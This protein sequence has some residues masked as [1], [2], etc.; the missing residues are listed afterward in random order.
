MIRYAMSRGM[1]IVD[2]NV[3]SLAQLLRER[4]FHTIVPPTGMSDEDIVDLFCAGRIIITTN[5]RDFIDLAPIY[6]FGIIEVTSRAM[7]DPESVAKRISKEF[8]KRSLKRESPF[9]LKITPH[10]ITFRTID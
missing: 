2:E 4:K 1:L 9:I 8:S 7:A 5:A 3:S 6:E 10:R